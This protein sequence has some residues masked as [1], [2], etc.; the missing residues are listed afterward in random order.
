MLFQSLSAA[1]ET[2]RL[3]Y[4]KDIEHLE[5]TP[6]ISLVD[7][8][9]KSY[10][11]SWDAYDE[12]TIGGAYGNFLVD[13]IVTLYK[14][15]Q[16]KKAAEMQAHARTYKRY[17]TRFSPNL[18]DFVLKELAEDMEQA[19][20]PTAQGTVQSYLMN[21]YYQLAIDEDEVAESYLTIA[22]Q[23]YDR[24][25]KSSP[26]RKSRG[27]PPRNQMQIT[28]RR[29]QA[30]HPAPWP[31]GWRNASPEPRRIHSG[32]RRNRCFCGSVGSCR[33]TRPADCLTY[34]FNFAVVPSTRI[35]LGLIVV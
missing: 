12:N 23:L 13:A 21:A 9:N 1:F 22:K 8:V 35:L 34:C 14:F 16:K 29:R 3:V 26:A 30:A 28:S 32:S 20:Q 24:Y 19:S 5:M 31:N 7:A 6:N 2:G 15:G 18:D 4:L 25:Q 33:P 10:M 11:D 27:L 17:G